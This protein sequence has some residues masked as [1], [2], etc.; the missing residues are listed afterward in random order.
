MRNTMAVQK[1][2]C[3]VGGTGDPYMTL[4][5]SVGDTQQKPTEDSRR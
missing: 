2:L 3:L 5:G 4:I 1:L